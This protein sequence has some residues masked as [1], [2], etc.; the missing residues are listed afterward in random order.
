MS[1]SRLTSLGAVS[2]LAAAL[3]AGPALADG[4]PD[5]RAA[6]APEERL[7]SLSANIG[8]TTD[9]VFRGFSQT[10]EGPA[11]QGGV[12]ATCGMFYAGLWASSLDFAGSTFGSFSSTSFF[13]A[14]VEMDW[15]VGIK[16]KTGPITW[17]LGI[18]YY[19]YPRAKSVALPINRDLDYVELKVGASGDIWR[20]GTLGATVFYSPDYQ[21][22]SGST[23]TVEG[24]FT[25]VLPRQGMF[26]PSVS[27]TIGHQVNDASGAKAAAYAFSYGGGKDNY[28]YWNAGMTLGFL[29]KWSVDVRYWDTNLPGGSCNGATFQCDQR[30]VGSLKVTF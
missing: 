18:I 21:L 25:Q 6:T 22:N 28:T 23:W 14:S 9:Y 30:V 26:S 2:L 17:D 10:A 7:C 12:D 15:Y 3:F 29:E 20:G 8:V 1:I 27:A 24:A 19:S 11:V 13:D 5:R 4:M 16:P